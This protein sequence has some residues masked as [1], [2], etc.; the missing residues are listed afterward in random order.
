MEA[1]HST[2][3][4][5][6]GEEQTMES[7]V[8]LL[9]KGEFTFSKMLVQQRRPCRPRHPTSFS[10]Q[11]RS[12]VSRTQTTAS[13]CWCYIFCRVLL[14]FKHPLITHVRP[15]NNKP[16]IGMWPCRGE[17][18]WQQLRAIFQHPPWLIATRR[19]HA[20][21]QENGLDSE[22]KWNPFQSDPSLWRCVNKK[23]QTCK[24]L[25]WRRKPILSWKR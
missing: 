8:I 19:R 10:W 25:R 12:V 11:S 1:K 18:S 3:Y 13:V 4:Y 6:A 17:A 22:W 21:Q 15:I 7:N 2:L 23:K 14:N 16:P 9:I 24:R 5:T 20:N